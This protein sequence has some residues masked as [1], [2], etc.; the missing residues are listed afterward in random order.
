MGAVPFVALAIAGPLIEDAARGHAVGALVTYGAVILS[1]LGGVHWG[2]AIARYGLQAGSQRID[3][4]LLL[5]VAPSLIAWA[6]LFLPAPAGLL[7]LAAAFLMMFFVD[8]HFARRRFAPA[9]Y[10]TL[11]APLTIIVTASLVVG[12]VV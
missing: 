1:F 10:P 11:R 8:R 5:S 9:W 12:A 6:A 7:T 2:L 4:R 3:R